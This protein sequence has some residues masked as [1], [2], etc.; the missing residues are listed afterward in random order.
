M[1]SDDELLFDSGE[2]TERGLGTYLS[3]ASAAS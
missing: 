2:P 1:T 3:A